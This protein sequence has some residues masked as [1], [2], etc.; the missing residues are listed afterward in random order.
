[1][2]RRK[3]KIINQNSLYLVNLSSSSL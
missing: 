3:K 1:M 2:T